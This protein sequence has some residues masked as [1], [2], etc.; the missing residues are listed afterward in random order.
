VIEDALT[1]ED[2]PE[3]FQA[4]W[5]Y[6]PFPWQADLV[7]RLTNG[8][9]ARRGDAAEPGKWPDVL[10]LPTGSGKTAALDVAVFHLAL[11]A[12]RGEE[13]RAPV[14]IAFVVDRR[15]IVDDAFTRAERL[16]RAMQWSLLDDEEA[17][18][19][20]PKDAEL[21]AMLYRVRT[22]P[23]VKRVAL[24][25]R[26]LAGDD[27]PPLLA[28][29]LRGGAPREDDWARTPVQ[30][31][32]L[33]STVDQVGSRL[34]F[35]GYGVSDSM[36]PV[37][38]GLLGSDCLLLLDEAH[39]SEPFRQALK[40]IK[41]LRKPDTAPF[42][43][44]LLT[45]T[46]SQDETDYVFELSEED[47]THR[48]LAARINAPKPARLV[49]IA[50]KQGVDTESRRIDAIIAE[51]K[52]VFAELRAGG[53]WNPA[54]GIVVNRVARA[55]A[56]FERLKNDL[57]PTGKGIEQPPEPAIDLTLIVGAARSVDRDKI[58]EK[59][60]P[61]CT[62]QA[63]MQRDL[64]KPL[65]VVATQTIEA[66]VDIDFDGLVTEAAA[67]DALRQRFGRVN[68]AGRSIKS[69]AVVLA[70]KEDVGAKADDPI[71]R[72][73]I[74]TTWSLLQ[75]LAQL[76]IATE[77][78]VDF[79][80]EAMR[81]R[82]SRDE[83]AGLAAPTEGAPVLMPAYADLW[84]QTSPIPAADPEVALFLH[85]ADRA[86][87]SVQI[88]WRADIEREDLYAAWRRDADRAR[89]V[90]LLALMP[91]RA[92][93]AVEVPIWAARAFLRQ[94]MEPLADLSDAPGREPGEDGGGGRPAFC[95]AGKESER[96][97]VVYAYEL[98]NGDLIVVPAEYGGCDEWGWNP[99]SNEQVIDVADEAA[100]PYRAGR[101]VVR[102]T[103][104][105]IAQGFRKSAVSPPLSLAQE[106]ATKLADRLEDRAPALL[107]TV[108]E[109][110]LPEEMKKRL[111]VLKRH[112]KGR[113]ERT[114]AYGSDSEGRPSGVVFVSPA[115][116]RS[117]AGH[118]L[119]TV[120]MGESLAALPAT[121]DDDLG[122]AAESPT[123]LAEHCR[124]VQRWA[125]AFAHRAG[126]PAQ[127]VSDVTL[128]ALLH[129]AGKA[130]P[131]YQTYYAGG[132]PYGFDF[133]H[134]LA[135]SGQRQLPRD[136]W[137]RA[138]LPDHWRHEALS[139][140][141][142]RHHARF[143][144]AKDPML[145]LWLIGSHHGH[146]RPLFPHAD[147]RDEQVCTGLLKACGGEGDLQPEPGPQ[148]L[149]FEFKGLDWAQMF[150][151]LKARYGI[152]GLARLEAF[153]RLADHR[154]SEAGALPEVSRPYKE[155]AE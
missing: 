1:S 71:Y 97:G 78:A 146:G 9:D 142:A 33:C 48:I 138:G 15:L 125:E 38:A 66:G 104:E 19:L 151:A 129:D 94:Q 22:A 60:G 79:G 141:I 154:A 59:L 32:I 98:R 16:C 118:G 113:L 149:A 34:L 93:E 107:D 75:R 131:R 72:D 82:L 64:P 23:V 99:A 83:A 116:V 112:G 61:I 135:K 53:V 76:P 128:A 90:D 122:A 84:S 132:N 65:V 5:G 17:K 67:L 51:V 14:R 40:A 126:L 52:S 57:E 31:T 143:E 137:E 92:A 70:H 21:A 26:R 127:V 2:F 136:A 29:S 124:A 18:V 106:L 62:R 56:V 101:L 3:F 147:N 47:R 85:G 77:E 13:R 73:R 117:I 139:V 80:I 44:A 42:G 39:L 91:P 121:E 45:A 130:D 41:R 140:R 152:W 35:R 87:A 102:V 109:L 114:F 134:V 30:P 43:V 50:G 36:K 110:D 54:I 63:D 153:V 88:V 105:L 123:S 8:R 155:A 25:L 49:E 28:R 7:R 86:P 115:G 27:Q 133:E 100:W 96:S 10:D 120:N 4:V 46:P 119:A 150:E 74:A 148:S 20:T 103:A 69:K 111:D 108:L 145:V 11:E 6:E 81:R 144:S 68:R 58:A 95:Y 55:R 12:A 37:H 89:L 24:Q